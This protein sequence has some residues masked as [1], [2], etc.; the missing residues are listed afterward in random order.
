M[1]LTIKF[2][3][4]A[5]VEADFDIARFTSDRES[6][7]IEFARVISTNAESGEIEELEIC[8][9]HRLP[10]ANAMDTFLGLFRALVDHEKEYKTGHGITIPD[11]KE[12]D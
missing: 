8:S 7:H 3:E 1:P 4:T 2:R 12:S 9:T 10:I 6:L 5:D 11:N